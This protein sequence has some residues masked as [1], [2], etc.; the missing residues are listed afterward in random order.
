MDPEQYCR[1]VE[2]YL[3]RKNDGHLIRIVGPSFDRVSGWASRAI[4]L[5][6]VCAGIDRYVER[7][8]ARGPRRRPVRIDFCEADVL[9]AFDQWRRAVGVRA[10]AAADA[11]ADSDALDTVPPRASLPA[12]LGRVIAKLTLLRG[13]GHLSSASEAVVAEVVRELDAARSGAKQIRGQSRMDL[14]ARLHEIDRHV[15]E[16]IRR[17]YLPEALAALKREVDEELEP[18]RSRMPSDAFHLAAARGLARLMRERSGIPHI[19]LE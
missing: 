13:G 6:V 16:T 3:C 12:H 10:V 11:T 4:P 2:A 19:A 7:Y 8:Y 1:D 9:D 17:D 15:L 18:Y 5:N 14:L